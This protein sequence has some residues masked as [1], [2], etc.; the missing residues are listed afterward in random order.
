[1]KKNSRR[2]IR[3]KGFRPPPLSIVSLR[4]EPEIWTKCDWAGRAKGQTRSDFVRDALANATR[5]A[6]PPSPREFV[7]FPVPESELARWQELAEHRNEEVSTTVRT[8]MNAAYDYELGD[9]PSRSSDR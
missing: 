2:E 5:D 8:Y 6:K 3:K 9:A 1:M 7:G 4:I